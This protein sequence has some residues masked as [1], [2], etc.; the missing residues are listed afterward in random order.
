MDVLKTAK[1]AMRI[2]AESI[3]FDGK[4]FGQTL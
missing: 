4:K 3:L 2:E 1:E